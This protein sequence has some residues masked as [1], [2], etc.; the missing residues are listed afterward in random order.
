MEGSLQYTLHSS[1]FLKVPTA[2]LRYIDQTKAKGLRVV[3]QFL[4]HG[5]TPVCGHQALVSQG[6]G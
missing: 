2:S 5:E 6:L 4:P 3:T 1:H